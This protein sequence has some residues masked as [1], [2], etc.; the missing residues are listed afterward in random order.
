MRRLSYAA[1]RR[2]GRARSG[3]QPEG[4]AAERRSRAGRRVPGRR[5][6]GASRISKASGRPG[7]TSRCSGRR[8]TRTRSSSPTPSVRTGTSASPTSSCVSPTRAGGRAAPSR[9]WR[10]PTA[11]PSSCRTC[12]SAGGPSMVV[13]SAW[14]GG[15][16]VTDQERKKRTEMMDYARALLQATEACRNKPASCPGVTLGRSVVPAAAATSVL[17]HRQASRARA[18][19]AR[20]TVPMGPRIATSASGACRRAFRASAATGGSCSPR[21]RSP[22]S[23]TS[24]R[25]GLAA[26]DPRHN[27][28]LTPPSRRAPVVGRFPRPL[29]RQHADGGRHQLLAQIELPGGGREPAPRGEVDAPAPTPCKYR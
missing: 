10:A 27:G 25:A 2:G 18:A 22:F 19:A 17:H 12:R 24:V 28:L 4:G 26:G 9:T 1:V 21:G 7:P 16:P 8:A 29:G 5:R 6:R 13:D 23:T 11:R 14:T 20:S 3:G 15:F